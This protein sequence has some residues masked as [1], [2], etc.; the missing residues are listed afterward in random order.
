M[1]T[2]L[3]THTKRNH[4]SYLCIREIGDCSLYSLHFRTHCMKIHLHD[5]F[6][7]TWHSVTL[8]D[9]LKL[10]D[11]TIIPTISISSGKQP[12]A[13]YE[14]IPVSNI[15]RCSSETSCKTFLLC[16]RGW[17]WESRTIAIAT[18]LIMNDPARWTVVV[19]RWR[20]PIVWITHETDTHTYTITVSKKWRS[21]FS[22]VTRLYIVGC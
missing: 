3:C 20:Q 4:R 9:E 18:W 8:S 6:V 14:S 12:A 2:L 10:R 22:A 7:C 15:T 13:V 19:G 5:E 11:L 17:Q 1:T 21:A 16:C